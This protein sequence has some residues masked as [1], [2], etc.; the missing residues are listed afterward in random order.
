MTERQNK[1]LPKRG[2]V[3]IV[4]S[5][6][7]ILLT[8]AAGLAWASASSQRSTDAREAQRQATEEDLESMPV[9]VWTVGHDAAPIRYEE[10]RGQVTPARSSELAFRRSG[11]IRRIFVQAGDRVTAGQ[12][13]AEL[14]DLD[15]RAQLASADAQRDQ[16][17]ASLMEA[18]RGPRYQTIATAK[19]DVDRLDSLLQQ[20]TANLQRQR[21]LHAQNA[22]PKQALDDATFAV[23]TAQAALQAERQR[24]LELEEGTRTEQ[25]DGARANFK[26]AEA[27]RD[28]AKVQFDFAEVV[29]PFDGHVSRRFLDE[30]TIV[31]PGERVLKVIEDGR[32]E[33]RLGLPPDRAAELTLDQEVAL[34]IAEHQYQGRVIRREPDLDPA[35][36]TQ[37]VEIAILPTAAFAPV[38]GQMAVLRL[39]RNTAPDEEAF[40]IPSTA[41][42]HGFRGLWAIYRLQAT[43]KPPLATVARSDVRVLETDGDWVLVKGRL[44]SGEQIVATGVHRVGVGMQVRPSQA[45]LLCTDALIKH[46]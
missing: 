20:A 8:L 2:S 30:G 4:L 17:A 29:A 14:D 18:Q 10:Y 37:A 16:A 27:A 12:R 24:L 46:E 41:L 6:G 1:V 5:G 21:T 34:V 32:L 25:I 31:Q 28:L 43:D 23:S 15:L 33:T 39:V 3:G 26:A 35:T 40:W 44:Q 36:Q 38:P 7:V 9:A 13:L 11:I 19:A 22:S 45:D 42:V